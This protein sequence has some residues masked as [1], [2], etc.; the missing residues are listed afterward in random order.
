M[1]IKTAMK[2]SPHT[3]QNGDHQKDKREMLMRKENP[4]ALLVRMNVN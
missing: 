3:G 4:C 2:L 1:Q